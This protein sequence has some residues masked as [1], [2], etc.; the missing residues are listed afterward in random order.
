ML[1]GWAR[2]HTWSNSADIIRFWTSHFLNSFKSQTFLVIHIFRISCYIICIN[3]F[4]WISTIV[5][6]W[7]LLAFF[8][9]FKNFDFI[10]FISLWRIIPVYILIYRITYNFLLVTLNLINIFKGFG[11][12]MH[13][14]VII[15][16]WRNTFK[17]LHYVIT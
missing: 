8:I 4:W 1:N 7:K 5:L 10:I 16:L 11:Y 2:Y 6:N 15:Y 17:F 13:L 3:L 9:E 14:F 12:C